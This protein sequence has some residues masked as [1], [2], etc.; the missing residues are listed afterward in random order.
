MAMLYEDLQLMR[1]EID[2]LRN[3]G[4]ENLEDTVSKLYKDIKT[5]RNEIN[6]LKV[7]YKSIEKGNK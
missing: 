5:M 6:E 4:D 2:K 7:K 3:Q 1:D